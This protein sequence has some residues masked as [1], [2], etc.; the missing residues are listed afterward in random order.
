MLTREGS[1]EVKE[2]KMF[3]PLHQH[4]ASTSSSQSQS[5]RARVSRVVVCS[6]CH[7][8][9]CWDCFVHKV[10]ELPFNLREIVLQ[11][12]FDSGEA[13]W[14][15]SR[16]LPYRYRSWRVYYALS[17]G[18]DPIHYAFIQKTDWTWQDYFTIHQKA[19][20]YGSVRIIF[21]AIDVD[22]LIN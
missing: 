14:M 4:E 21:Y 17:R 8:R 18:P 16:E 5:K 20:I 9:F 15:Y 2:I 3:R 22:N 19:L 6:Q 1:A 10:I 11:K 12:W 13:Q 7:Y